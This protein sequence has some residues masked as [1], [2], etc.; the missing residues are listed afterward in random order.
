MFFSPIPSIRIQKLPYE[1]PSEG[2]SLRCRY[3]PQLKLPLSLW[4]SSPASLTGCRALWGR[5]RG[6]CSWSD[7]WRGYRRSAELAAH[8]QRYRLVY[9]PWEDT[10]S[11]TLP[12][13]WDSQI[14]NFMKH[15]CNNCSG[16]LQR[17]QRSVLHSTH[18]LTNHNIFSIFVLQQQCN[19]RW[20]NENWWWWRN[21]KSGADKHY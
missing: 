16:W 9:S 20:C 4:L 13:S 7:H 14:Q 12:I 18:F 17:L 3:L 15:N 11:L 6:D 5:G 1:E 8:I 21:S 19:G 2:D 10:L